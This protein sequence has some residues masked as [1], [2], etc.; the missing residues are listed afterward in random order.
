MDMND[1]VTRVIDHHIDNKAYDDQ[2][3]E[4]VV[5]FIGSACSLVAMKF[6]EH[7]D[8]FAP[9]FEPGTP[10]APNLAYLMAA[11]VVLDTYYF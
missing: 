6:E 10:E 3:V 4:K 5:R 9:D 11:A 1:K 8:K 2:L 7:Y